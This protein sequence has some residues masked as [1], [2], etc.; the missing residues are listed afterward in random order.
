MGNVGHA[1]GKVES[2]VT[3]ES[4]KGMND[5]QVNSNNNL[6]FLNDDEKLRKGFQNYNMRVN[7]SN[8]VKRV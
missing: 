5:Y 2:I 7:L 6:L 3:K 8:Y 1:Y 4:S